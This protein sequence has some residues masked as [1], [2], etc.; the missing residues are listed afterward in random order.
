MK[1]VCST[2]GYLFNVK[3]QLAQEMKHDRIRKVYLTRQTYIYVKGREGTP[4][5]AAEARQERRR[6]NKRS[7][8]IG[9]LYLGLLAAILASLLLWGSVTDAAAAAVLPLADYTGNIREFA[10]RVIGDRLPRQLPGF[11]WYETA[12]DL[13][14]DIAA[15]TGLRTA[16]VAGIVAAL[17]PAN[18]WE[19]NILDARGLIEDPTGYVVKTYGP[20]RKKAVQILTGDGSL[21][22]I[23]ILEILGG[24]DT[25]RKT[26]TFF[27]NILGDATGVTI[28]AHAFAVALGQDATSWGEAAPRITPRR[29][30]DVEASYLQVAEE[31][32]VTGY[33][34]QS[35]LWVAH[36]ARIEASR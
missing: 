18:L 23:D 5:S 26:R 24:E 35:I 6:E 32:N 20:Q 7:A 11:L 22:D 21:S 15:A 2:T 25:A 31:C 28:D 17:S 14:S 19:Q 12:R 3:H 29:Y 4:V 10:R 1:T 36:K 9:I 8:L 30:R 16:T 27:A 34:L 33:A 13:C